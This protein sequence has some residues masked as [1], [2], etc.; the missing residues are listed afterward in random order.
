MKNKLL[1]L[2]SKYKNSNQEKKTTYFYGIIFIFIFIFAL[3]LKF[4]GNLT[5]KEINKNNNVNEEKLETNITNYDDI[6]NNISNNY[7]E[8]IQVDIYDSNFLT[9]EYINVKKDQDKKLI[10]YVDLNKSTI[11]NKVPDNIDATFITPENIKKLMLSNTY[12]KDN[13]YMIETNNWIK[14]YNEVTNKNIEK[15]ITGEIEITILSTENNE[16]SLLLNLTNLY[17]NTN[18]DYIKVI[19]HIEFY[20]IN[21]VDLSNVEIE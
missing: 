1:N 17:K 3:I 16:L 6:F 9:K 14:L 12:K 15:K 8:N 18:Y 13:K 10:T 19:Y 4:T 5:T 7:E 11:E 21:N 20:N 2:I